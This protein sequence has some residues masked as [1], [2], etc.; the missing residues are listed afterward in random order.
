MKTIRII[1][2]LPFIMCCAGFGILGMIIGGDAA[3]EFVSALAKK[4][5]A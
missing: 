3:Q 2:A 5:E 4:L 1:L